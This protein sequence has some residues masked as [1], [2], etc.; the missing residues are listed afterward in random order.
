MDQPIIPIAPK[1]STAKPSLRPEFEEIVKWGRQLQSVLQNHNT[2]IAE[3]E[4]PVVSEEETTT[5][6]IGSSLTIPAA[7]VAT[8]GEIL[9]LRS[10]GVS[11]TSAADQT[12]KITQ[13]I[14]QAVS[15]GAVLF[16][17]SGEFFIRPI[18]ISGTLK[19][20]GFG[21]TK[22]IFKA[23]VNYDSANGLITLASGAK[24]VFQDL[25]IHGASKVNRVVR[26]NPG[27]DAIFNRCHISHAY[28]S[29]SVTATVCGL[30]V[31]G[32]GTF[33]FLDGKVTDITAEPDG[34]P[35]GNVPGTAR[36][37]SIAALTG[38]TVPDVLI[39]GS[40]FESILSGVDAAQ[41]NE[42]ADAIAYQSWDQTTKGNVRIIGNYFYNIGKRWFKALSPGGVFIG[43]TGENTST[44]IRPM[45][46]VVSINTSDWVVKGNKCTGGAAGF[47]CDV[48]NP[49]T[50]ACNNVTVV[51]NIYIQSS[52]DPH[53][54]GQ[55]CRAAGASGTLTTGVIIGD[56]H[57]LNTH[58]GVQV[59][60]GT[61]GVRVAGNRITATETGVHV[62]HRYSVETLYPDA[63]MVTVEHNVGIA[64]TYGVRWRKAVNSMPGFNIFTAADPLIAE[65][66]ITTMFVNTELFN[67]QIV[68][69]T[70]KGI[71]AP[72]LVGSETATTFSGPF[73]PQ[74]Q[75]ISTVSGG[76]TAFSVE[77]R[78][79]V[80]NG[81]AMLYYDDTASR[82]GLDSTYSSG[83]VKVFALAQAGTDWVT[84]NGT[85]FIFS[86]HAVPISGS[87]YDLGG[88]TVRWRHIY[89]QGS[90]RAGRATFGTGEL[91]LEALGTANRVIIKSGESNASEWT[92]V[93]PVDNPAVGDALRVASIVGTVATLEWAP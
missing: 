5:T 71:T 8:V 19:I 27:C 83:G 31:G 22:S 70:I 23:A 93:W 7:P 15:T 72:L 44:S 35:T 68:G 42:D 39:S 69:G 48:G 16:V 75:A 43:N 82:W 41:R 60:G 45:Y 74:A 38:E 58:I 29:V 14:E 62:G 76:K 17:P 61:I 55:G 51:D 50:W 32:G 25:A 52:T 11:T 67:L 47:F 81:R 56:N 12:T 6:V 92:Y 73:T 13:A 46:S 28:G 90:L 79:G 77:T 30:I 34:N 66:P 49:N 84:C 18:T 24:V 53:L 3:L 89:A 1:F 21:N 91:H 63:S 26:V 10:L 20:R 88:P 54:S 57:F 86:C 9:D 80:R 64:T 4:A 59:T 33:K 78:D 37:I 65:D 87:T 85:N 36:G 2:R 40:R